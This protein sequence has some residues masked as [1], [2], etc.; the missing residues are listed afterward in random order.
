MQPSWA[1]SE[2]GYHQQQ[3]EKKL[4]LHRVEC[5]C[6]S[7]EREKMKFIDLIRW[8]ISPPYQD[9]STICADVSVFCMLRSGL[10][11]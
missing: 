11:F 9:I 6:K 4:K 5:C 10:A 1:A 7:P 8:K 3:G 2:A